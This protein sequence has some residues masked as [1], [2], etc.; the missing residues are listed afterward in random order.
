[1][2]LGQLCKIVI[3]NVCESGSI[4]SLLI[5]RCDKTIYKHMHGIQCYTFYLTITTSFYLQIFIPLKVNFPVKGKDLVVNIEKKVCSVKPGKV[6]D[7]ILKCQNKFMERIFK[8][9]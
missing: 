5:N 1:M 8:I 6:L 3:A 4:I 7:K 9:L 2:T